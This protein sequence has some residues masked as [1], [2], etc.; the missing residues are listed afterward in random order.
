MKKVLPLFILTVFLISCSSVKKTQQA[1][2]YG[3]YDEAINIALKN[4]RTNKTKKGNQSYVLMLEEAFAKAVSRDKEKIKFLKEDDNSSNLESIYN[5][6]LLLN[7]RQNNVK[8]LL[9]LPI[10]NDGRNAK[11]KFEDYSSNI[12]NSKNKLSEY[13]YNH[14]KNQ[15]TSSLNKLDFR[16]I[17]N[18]LKYLDHINPNFK[19]TNLLL[20]EAHYKGTDFVYV[21]LENKTNKIIPIRLEN[22]LLN[23]DTYSLNNL[24]TIYNTVKQPNQLYDF[25]LEINFRSINISP[26][27]LREKVII[28][29]KQVKDGWKY[30][31]DNQGNA[32]KD[33]L[34]NTIKVDKFK[35]IKSKLHKYSQLKFTQVVGQINYY[36][37]KT[38]QLV[39]T[40]PLSSEFTFEHHFATYSG[41]KNAI[42]KSNLNLLQYKRIS[43]PSNEQMIYDSGENLKKKIK[44]IITN[45]NFR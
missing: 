10:L 18:D 5:L 39:K 41:N 43:F 36:N 31:I 35:T 17:Y 11:F 37:L 3:N 9:P 32:V 15:L 7:N 33:S 14:A 16:S 27:Q 2:N 6:Y 12:L 19:K 23:F 42:D 4:L 24:W 8:P 44:A 22:D 30:L 26:E 40:F 29:K 38:R 21:T 20:K 1:I 13:L 34:G 45:Y 28:Q 25:Q